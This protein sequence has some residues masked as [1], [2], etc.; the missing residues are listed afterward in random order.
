MSKTYLEAGFIPGEIVRVKDGAAIFDTGS[1]VVCEDP[2][3]NADCSSLIYKLIAGRCR[4]NNSRDGLPGGYFSTEHVEHLPRLTKDT[5]MCTYLRVEDPLL[6][7]YFNLLTKLGFTWASGRE[8]GSA[9]QQPSS[10]TQPGNE[11]G[12]DDDGVVRYTTSHFYSSMDYVPFTLDFIKQHCIDM[13]TFTDAGFE[14]HRGDIIINVENRIVYPHECNGW[15]KGNDLSRLYDST[16]IV[17][18]RELEENQTP[19]TE[20]EGE[21]LMKKTPCEEKGW[22]VGDLFFVNGDRDIVKLIED[23]G[24][25]APYFKFITGDNKGETMYM[26]IDDLSPCNEVGTVNNVL[27]TQGWYKFYDSPDSIGSAIIGILTGVDD[28]DPYPFQLDDENWYRYCTPIDEPLQPGVKINL[29]DEYSEETQKLYN[30]YKLI[31]SDLTD[32][33]MTIK[34]FVDG[35][36]DQKYTSK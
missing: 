11:L 31:A 16:Y 4:Y 28:G 33:P 3:L 1:L 35:G 24:S 9:N 14:I 30:T 20:I 25:N 23:D 12:V 18:S 8:L 22:A 21:K 34:E 27:Y 10:V 26:D 17:Y 5:L 7:D 15:K 13:K 6:P 2:N 19:S 32:D 29:L 36:Y